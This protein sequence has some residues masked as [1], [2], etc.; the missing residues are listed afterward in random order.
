MREPAW[1]LEGF[2]EEAVL[3]PKAGEEWNSGCAQVESWRLA[4]TPQSAVWFSG[5]ASFSILPSRKD[6]A[7][8]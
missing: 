5:L 6:E 1:V 7:Q 4:T 8:S 3:N 2:W